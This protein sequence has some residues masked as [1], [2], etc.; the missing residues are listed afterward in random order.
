MISSRYYLTILS[1]IPILIAQIF[2]ARRA[3]SKVG[4]SR[5]RL[6]IWR[7]SVTVGSLLFLLSVVSEFDGILHL[8]RIV[9]TTAQTLVNTYGLT[10]VVGV[11]IYVLFEFIG[12]RLPVAFKED[13]RHALRVIT[14]AAVAAPIAAAG[15][16]V[17]VER[18]NFEVCETPVRIRLLPAELDGLRIVQISDIHLGP[19]LDV[20]TLSK[21][22]DSA[23][24]LHAHMAFITGDLIT[25]K[26]DPL[27]AC[28]SQIARLK[29]D[30]APLGCLGNH[31]VYADAVDDTTTKGARLGIEFLRNRTRR[32]QFRGADI[33]VAGV[34]Y[35]PF[36]RRPHYLRQAGSLVQ[37][38][39]FNILLSHNPDVFPVAAAKGFDLTLSGHM[40][41]GQVT[42][43][44]LSPALNPGRIL[45]PFV[46]GLYQNGN[47]SC[48][49]TRGIG[50]LGVPARLGARPEITLLTLRRA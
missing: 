21:V 12:N 24:E 16:G 31:E 3:R 1:V 33:N 23:N 7:I 48:Y 36:D 10:S 46:R 42:C 20:K 47:H 38:G 11:A 29:A 41:G 34:D 13:R 28:L 8:P 45:T 27:D 50:T 9:A 6:Q 5:T 18:T 14:G 44:F 40:H 19:Y 15:F 37:P 32:L 26:G 30:A 22:I 49:V 35:E 43:E 4:N 25:A 2:L 39:V 17:F